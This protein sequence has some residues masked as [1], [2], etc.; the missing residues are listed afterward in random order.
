MKQTNLRDIFSKKHQKT[1]KKNEVSIKNLLFPQTA[2]KKEEE[3][4]PKLPLNNQQQGS[5]PIDE[6]V[7]LFIS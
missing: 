2:P 5:F 3:D 1:I 7:K 6:E 4:N